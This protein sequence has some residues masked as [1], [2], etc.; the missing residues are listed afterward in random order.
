[1]EEADGTLQQYSIPYSSLAQSLRPGAQQFTATAGKMDDYNTSEKP[2]FYEV[3]FMRG[4]TNILTVYTGAQYSQNYQAV[5]AG[6]PWGQ[7]RGQ[8]AQT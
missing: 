4:I 1:M 3:T 8:S 5:L 6:G 2:L 7:K